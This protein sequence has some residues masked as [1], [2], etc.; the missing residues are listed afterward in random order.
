M[1]IAQASVFVSMTSL[2][3]TRYNAMATG[4]LFLFTSFCL[5]AG[6]TIS[7]S[8]LDMR[9]RRLLER[10]FTGEGSKEVSLGEKSFLLPFPFPCSY[11]Y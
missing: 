11:G 5:S 4:G 1:G 3:H 6:I 10:H 8:A 2:L 9:F 7:N